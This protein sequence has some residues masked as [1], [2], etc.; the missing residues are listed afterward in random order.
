M[1]RTRFLGPRLPREMNSEHGDA[2]APDATPKSIS[3]PQGELT[4]LAPDWPGSRT[5]TA[6]EIEDRIL[7]YA[8][9]EVECYVDEF[10]MDGEGNIYAPRVQISMWWE[11]VP[12][13]TSSRPQP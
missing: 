9:D 6:K 8:S 5:E 10:Y 13:G 3:L 12:A 7:R 2:A 4:L 1:K 11:Q